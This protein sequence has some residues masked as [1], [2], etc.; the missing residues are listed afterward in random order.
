MIVV[1]PLA[2]RG[3]RFKNKG[4]NI[5][6]PLIDIAGKPILYYAFQSLKNV[7]YRKLIFIVL[8]EHE[9]KY[10]ISRVINDYIVDD[11]EIIL[12]D[13]VT[14]GQ[15][16]TVL[17]ARTYF[18]KDEGILILS[19]D[20]FVK[21]KIY[22]ELENITY[23]GLISV[24]D[25]PGDDWSF[26]KTNIYGDVIEVSEKRRISKN[27]STGIYFFKDSKLFE[28]EADEMIKRRETTN[29]E[30]YIMPLYSSYIKNKKIIKL[31]NASSMWDLGT[32]EKKEKFE[33]YL[34][35]EKF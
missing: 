14:K 7:K 1:I 15:L 3:S 30:Y 22:K 4:Y 31:S 11:F 5:P 33:K 18:R 19:S 26:A 21:S 6:K 27:A 12:I 34:E 13:S 24:Y 2:G 16:C 20:T 32:P 8:S 17:E 25:I 23:D 29:N 10:N 9:K 28:Y 35:N